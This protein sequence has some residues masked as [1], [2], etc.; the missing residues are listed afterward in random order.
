M[1]EIRTD[2]ISASN[3]TGP[4]TLTKQSASKMWCNQDNGTTINQSLNVS[5]LTDNGTGDYTHN[6]TS[7]FANV[8]YAG[9]GVINT[10]S[11]FSNFVVNKFDAHLVGSI[12]FSCANVNSS[13]ANTFT[14]ADFTDV[15]YHINGDLA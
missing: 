3:G 2:T 1:S 4:V 13:A 9:S 5:S 10:G 15:M 7:N 14:R 12:R 8:H 11:N 6:F